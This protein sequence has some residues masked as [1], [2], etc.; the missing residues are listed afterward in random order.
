MQNQLL[1]LEKNGF[2]YFFLFSKLIFTFLEAEL[3]RMKLTSRIPEDSKKNVGPN[4]TSKTM[5]K[6]NSVKDTAERQRN[7][8]KK[9]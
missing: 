3:G 9:I 4:S 5:Q 7:C 8:F 2:F 1:H 6:V